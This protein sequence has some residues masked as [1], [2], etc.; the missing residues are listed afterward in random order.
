MNQLLVIV[1]CALVSLATTATLTLDPI[2]TAD[3]E[4]GNDR[5]FVKLDCEPAKNYTFTF[6]PFAIREITLMSRAEFFKRVPRGTA[7]PLTSS[8]SAA[9]QVVISDQTDFTMRFRLTQIQEGYFSCQ[10][11]DGMYK[12]TEVGLAGN[13]CRGVSLRMFTCVYVRIP[14]RCATYRHGSRRLLP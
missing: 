2:L 1:I 3:Y 13:L 11:P 14:R 8:G 5:S 4:Q 10:S 12:S 7:L 6:H 9:E